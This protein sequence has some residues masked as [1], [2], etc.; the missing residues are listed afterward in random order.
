LKNLLCEKAWFEKDASENL[1]KF[2]VFEGFEFKNNVLRD[3]G[4]V[5]FLKFKKI[6]N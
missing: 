6:V 4:C 2:K 3:I 5:S 1:C